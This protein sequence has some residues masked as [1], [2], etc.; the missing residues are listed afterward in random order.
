MNAF[1]NE[2]NRQYDVYKDVIPKKMVSY[3]LGQFDF[4]KL[5]GVDSEEITD[6]Q[7]CNL[8]GDLNKQ[9]KKD[10]NNATIPVSVLPT[11]I[12]SLEYKKDSK[13]TLEMR[14]TL[15][16]VLVLEYTTLQQKLNQV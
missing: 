13:S 15:I 5:V 8:R 1:K 7:T 9:I 3:L 11:K 6:I 16:G 2:L 10:N 12:I 4:Y 14:Q